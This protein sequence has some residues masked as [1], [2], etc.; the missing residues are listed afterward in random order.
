[1]HLDRELDA[2]KT[3]YHA[4]APLDLDTRL[5]VLATLCVWFDL[6]SIETR[7]AII[8]ETFARS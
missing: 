4:L 6:I 3:V 1:M 2:L 5:R 8:A 7:T